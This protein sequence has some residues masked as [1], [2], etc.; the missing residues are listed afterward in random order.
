MTTIHSTKSYVNVVV[1]SQNI[2]L[3]CRSKQLQHMIF[4]YFFIKTFHLFLKVNNLWL[5]LGL[6]SLASITIFVLRVIKLRVT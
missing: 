6:V 3:Y 1:P 5:L 4:F 2:L